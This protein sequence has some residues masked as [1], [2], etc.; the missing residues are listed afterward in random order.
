MRGAPF[1]FFPVLAPFSLHLLTLHKCW[2]YLRLGT[3]PG[4]TLCVG[5]PSPFHVKPVVWREEEKGDKCITEKH[6]R[7][8]IVL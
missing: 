1:G 3:L 4:P 8:Y 2:D 5:V 6:A 7:Q